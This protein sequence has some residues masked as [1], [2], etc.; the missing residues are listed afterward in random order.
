MD[1]LQEHYRSKIT[2][3]L[4]PDKLVWSPYIHAENLYSINVDNPVASKGVLK[5]KKNG[6]MDDRVPEIPLSRFKPVFTPL[7]KFDKASYPSLAKYGNEFRTTPENTTEESQSD[8]EE[9]L[10]II[11]D[12]ELEDEFI[13]SDD[14][15]YQDP[16]ETTSPLVDDADE[17]IK[18]RLRIISASPIHE[19][20][21][22]K[23]LKR[24]PSSRNNKSQT[25][26]RINQILKHKRRL[27]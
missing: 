8:S 13:A 21:V 18:T 2:I 5:L 20:L 17:D 25:R 6:N 16:I 9:D 1:Q 10:A 26:M 3:P 14:R 11:S 15:N 12:A 19:S 7:S 27:R 4:H 23:S 24:P 22:S